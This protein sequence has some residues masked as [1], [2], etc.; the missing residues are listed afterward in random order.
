MYYGV[1]DVDTACT[2]TAFPALDSR[3]DMSAV[4]MAVG[5]RARGSKVGSRDDAGG[6]LADDS[7]AKKPSRSRGSH[8]R[9]KPMTA[10]AVAA[11]GRASA[12][13]ALV[14]PMRT[15]GAREGGATNY[16]SGPPI[17]VSDAPAA[18][19]AE[20]RARTDAN[21]R[22]PPSSVFARQRRRH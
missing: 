22:R 2:A 9:A 16:C 10:A 11:K 15:C 12:R 20:R 7:V 4:A 17:R 13:G 21:D 18:A 19:A 1:R 5:E 3:T 8:L 6:Q 14:G